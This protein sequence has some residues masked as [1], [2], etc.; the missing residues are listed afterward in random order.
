V[1]LLQSYGRQ[2]PNRIF[3]AIALGIASGMGYAF[4]IPIVMAA[5][6]PQDESLPSVVPHVQR[7][8]GVEVM[9]VGFAT[10][11]FA[12]CLFVLATRTLSRTLLI[13][14]S[15]EMAA[16]LRMSL[17]RRIA[18]ASYADLEKIGPARLNAVLTED[19]RRIIVGGQLFPDLLVNLITLLGLFCFLLYLNADAFRFVMIAITFGVLTYQVPVWFAKRVMVHARASLDRL[20][21]AVR[22]LIFGVKELKLDGRKAAYYFQHV[23]GR[24]E[25]ELLGHERRAYTILILG[26]SYGDLLSFLVIGVVSFV[27]INYHAIT[28]AE[29]SGVIMALLYVSG[30]VG[31]IMNAVPQLA[32]SRTSLGNVQRI[33]QSIAVEEGPP[34]AHDAAR[35]RWSRISFKGLEYRHRGSHGSEGF[36]IGPLDFHIDRGEVC[37][38]VGGNGS[39]KSTLSKVISLHY[40]PTGGQIEFDGCAVT[41]ENRNTWRESI[42]VVFSDYYL[43]DRLLTDVDPARLARA[44]AYL[45]ALGLA[46]KVSLEGGVFSTLSLSDGQRKRLALMVA[47]LDDKDLYVFDEWA[48]DQDP[49]FK[50]V[51]YR[52]M[53]PELRQRGKAVVVISHDDRFFD[54]AD[55]LLV[56]DTGRIKSLR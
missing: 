56:M 36:G 3:V 54:A 21:E 50:E 46:E 39:G 49:V 27:F 47:L 4:L 7:V 55:R 51:F 43:F 18:A 9:H 19:V 8:L 28:V 11:F 32:S 24:R 48:A 40:L 6:S 37:F 25:Q 35:P 12:V 10:L 16:G 20:H 30:P 52:Q 29:L 26:S 31:F 42:S 1:N 5:L 23:L 53:L 33:L 17:S 44:N 15:M 38:I 22:G 45:A 14:L 34:L 41:H 13:R 2:A